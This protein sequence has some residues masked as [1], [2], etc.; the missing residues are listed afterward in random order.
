MSTF[1]PYVPAHTKQR[2]FTSRAVFLGVILGLLFG[3][4]NTYLALKIGTT[5]S[6]S[7]PA[8]VISMAIL[9][10]F[11][12]SASILENNLVQTIASVGEGLAA[13]ITFSVPAL[14]LLGEHPAPSRIFL[15]SVLGGILGIL[16]MIPMRRYIIVHEHGK[17]PFP[18]GTACAE[19]LMSGDKGRSKALMAFL[20]IFVGALHKI[21]SS[22][23]Y[24]WNEV[25]T[26]VIG[27]L[28][29]TEFSMDCTPSLLGV[30][31]IV[32]PRIASL[33]FAGGALGWWILIPLIKVFGSSGIR[34]FIQEPFLLTQCLQMI[35]G[36]NI[37]AT[38]ELELLL[39][40][41]F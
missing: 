23:L 11:S 7:I 9:R 37:S 38:S 15:L 35:F 14:F 39:A 8:A 17:L 21:G 29:K 10:A 26:W 3:I 4:G 2:E 25:V 27:P 41:V 19:I 40:E 16:F 13:G 22:A 28:Q 5:V 24:L 12:K 1:Q 33:L 20:G 32:G 36:A 6:A 30:G 34:L 18:E 31:Y